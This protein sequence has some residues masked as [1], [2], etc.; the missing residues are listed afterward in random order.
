MSN[1][2]SHPSVARSV[3]IADLT[4]T[5]SGIMSNTFPLGCAYVAA[6]CSSIFKN[7][8]NLDLHKYPEDL[9]RALDTKLPSIMAFANY[10]WNLELSYEIATWIKSQSPETVIVFGGPNFPTDAEEQAD[11]LKYRHAIDFYI[12][13]E[14]EI[15]LAQLISQLMIADFNIDEVK[16]NKTPV[17]NCVYMYDNQLVV[18]PVERISDVNML[19]SPYL[20]GTLDKFFDK[21]LTPMLET[22]RGCPFSCTFCSDG[23][24]IKNKIHRFDQA[25]VK[26]EIDYMVT[27]VSQSDELIVTDLN[28]G[29]YK[30]DIPTAHLIAEA[31][32]NHRWPVIVK[33]SAGKNQTER[34]IDTAKILKGSW[35]IGAAIQSTDTE[36]LSN[37]KRSNI[38]LDS[39]NQFLGAMNELNDDAS[40]YT[41]I[42][43]GL[44]GDSKEKHLQTLRSAVES[45][46]VHVK[47]YQAMLLVGTDMATEKS[48]KEY[49]FNTKYRVMAGGAGVY[50]QNEIKIKALEVQEIVVGNKDM[51]FDDYLAC[52]LMDFVLEGFYNNAPFAEI[53]ESFKSMGYSIFDILLFISE[54]SDLYTRKVGEILDLYGKMSTS[55]LF[56]TFEEAR[57]QSDTAVELYEKGEFGFN[58]TL[59]CKTMLYREMRDTLE[60]ITRSIFEF[61]DEKG[62]KTPELERYFRQLSEYVFCRKHDITMNKDKQLVEFDF[63]FVSLNEKNFAINPI[64]LTPLAHPMKHIFY[65]EEEQQKHIDKSFAQYQAHSGG[66][67]RF[68][69]NQNLNKMYRKVRVVDG[70]S[71]EA[72]RHLKSA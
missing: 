10:S 14:G 67:S 68:L 58:E 7:K 44:P 64:S 63:D 47:S 8:I 55:N 25:R 26:E 15:G 42:I 60:T 70:V 50:T 57:F 16:A 36:V 54:R 3:Y 43:V 72:L 38:S 27:R 62:A 69:Y 34:V 2:T 31:Q 41:E 37:I 1:I 71:S 12:Q 46:V 45:G 61:L 49:G 13:S 20:T 66:F 33:G 19:P 53:F 40:T 52:R 39:Y 6:Y 24:K 28:F 51:P 35:I 21:P 48:R 59:E 30:Q 11:W 18:G 29:M 65:H 56:D 32:K 4:H 9:L 5:S 23:A 22:T 17:S